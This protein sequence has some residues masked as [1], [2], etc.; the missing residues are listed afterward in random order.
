[1]KGGGDPGTNKSGCAYSAPAANLLSWRG[2]DSGESVMWSEVA[3]NPFVL[4]G[5]WELCADALF[6]E[7]LDR[8][9]PL[10]SG[11][12]DDDSISENAVPS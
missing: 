3:C 9:R 4:P 2:C 8:S 11:P 7:L 1:M 5:D 10:V 6:L 12:G